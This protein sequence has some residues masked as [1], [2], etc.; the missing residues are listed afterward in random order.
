[1]LSLGTT[2]RTP[3]KKN[4]CIRDPA[5]QISD[6]QSDPPLPAPTW[7]WPLGQQSA[8]LPIPHMA[9]PL[10]GVRQKY[11]TQ[12]KLVGCRAHASRRFRQST[13]GK[14]GEPVGSGGQSARPGS[15][16]PGLCSQPLPP[17]PLASL[18]KITQRARSGHQAQGQNH[19][20]EKM[21]CTIEFMHL[22]GGCLTRNAFP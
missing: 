5:L 19:A 20:S 13:K 3:S 10:T 4:N 15:R 2:L 11:L 21:S 9:E 14:R 6:Q 16:K 12:W 8:R 7:A 18:S 22:E 1:M 17:I